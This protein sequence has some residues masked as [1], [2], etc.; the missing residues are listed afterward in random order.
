MTRYNAANNWATTINQGGG[1][2]DDP[3][4]TSLIVTDASGHPTTPF[5][6]T[7]EAEI[8]NVTGVAGNTLTLE[9]GQEGTSRVD[10]A[11][12][13]TVANLFTAEVQNDLWDA[14]ENIEPEWGAL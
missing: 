1:L 13:V 4:D 5:K 8:C 11:D 12:G 10:H 7:I 9:R 14:V 2:G 3:G 6:I